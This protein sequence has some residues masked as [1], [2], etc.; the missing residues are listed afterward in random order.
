[1]SSQKEFTDKYG[2]KYAVV[3]EGNDFS[4]VDAVPQIGIETRKNGIIPRKTKNYDY[5]LT[6]EIKNDGLYYSRLTGEFRKPLLRSRPEISG[7][8]PR[9]CADDVN[10]VIRCDNPR[11]WTYDLDILS[12]YSGIITLGSKYRM[13]KWIDAERKCMPIPSDKECFGQLTEI[14]F[15]NGKIIKTK[16]I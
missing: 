7:T 11:L 16:I 6:V 15:C 3:L 2:R 10:S 4:L 9:H 1:M 5:T 8:A 13:K 12:D 14:E